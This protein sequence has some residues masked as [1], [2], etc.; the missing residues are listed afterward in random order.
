MGIGAANWALAGDGCRWLEDFNGY[1]WGVIGGGTGTLYAA[2]CV[3]RVKMFQMPFVV[4]GTGGT[5]QMGPQ[6][7]TGYFYW[8]STT[9]TDKLFAM[10]HA[11]AGI[12]ANTASARPQWKQLTRGSV[13]AITQGDL[14]PSV[15]STL[16]YQAIYQTGFIDDVGATRYLLSPGGTELD[17]IAWIPSPTT[18][19]RK[20]LWHYNPWAW[21]GP[22]PQVVADI[23]MKCGIDA[24]YIDQPAFDNAYDA[25][26]LTTGDIPWK[27]AVSGSWPGCGSVWSIGVSRRVG[28]KCMDLIN[29]SIRHTR[30]LYFVN[31][32]GKL[33]VSSFTRPLGTVTGLGFDDGILGDVDWSYTTG[34]VFN[35]AVAS[36]GSGVRVSGNFTTNPDGGDYSAAEDVTLESYLGEK[37]QGTLTNAASIARYG[38]LF[39]PGPEF[40]QIRTGQPKKVTRSHY[41]HSFSNHTKFPSNSALYPPAHHWLPSDSKDRRMV[42]VTQDFRALDWGIGTKL[43][44]V[45]VTDDGMTINDC[46]CIERTYDF[47]RLTVTSVLMEVPANT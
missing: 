10:S 27:D 43:T 18:T 20:Y 42:T 45:A 47:D 6:I 16:I 32:A 29:E 4:G 36:W 24:A 46:W 7:D 1:D 9:G 37:L 13:S 19:I 21:Y 5:Q 30:D 17:S 15:S 22:V 38:E 14:P 23:V 40:L 11:S 39:L 33:S 31:E 25:Y 12:G 2:A 26:S 41:P 8:A 35:Y 3:S 28:Q 44:G 34:L